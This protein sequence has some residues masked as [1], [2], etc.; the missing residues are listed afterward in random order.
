MKKIKIFTL[1]DTYRFAKELS[2]KITPGTVVALNGDLGTG[3]TTLVKFI[4]KELGVEDYVNSPTFTIVNEHEGEKCKVNHI[5]FYRVNHLDELL[6]IGIDQYFNDKEITFVEWAELF[7]DILPK[8]KLTI[9]IE[10]DD[11]ERWLYLND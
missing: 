3:K 10:M 8:V 1:E 11:N 9:N 5:D 4:C 2:V 6:E 7:G